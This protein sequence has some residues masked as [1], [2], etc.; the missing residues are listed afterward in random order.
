VRLR[1]KSAYRLDSAANTGDLGTSDGF[2]E[3]SSKKH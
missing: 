1:V 2:I 3:F